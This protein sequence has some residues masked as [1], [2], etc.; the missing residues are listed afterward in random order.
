MYRQLKKQIY[1]KSVIDK[2]IRELEDRI[3]FKIQKQLGLHG[4]TFADIKIESLGNKDDKF[5]KTFSQVE[6]LDNDRLEL[7]EERKPKIRGQVISE[8]TIKPSMCI[9]NLI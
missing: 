9:T 7:V 8:E 2:N 3:R 5:L 6:H 1:D 4:T